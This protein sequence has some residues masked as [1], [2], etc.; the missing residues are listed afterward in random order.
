[1]SI[2]STQH[3]APAPIREN[4]SCVFSSRTVCYTVRPVKYFRRFGWMLCQWAVRS[5]TSVD[6]HHP[7]FTAL[8]Q[9]SAIPLPSYPSLFGHRLVIG[10]RKFGEKWAWPVTDLSWSAESGGFSD[11]CCDSVLERTWLGWGQL[12][13]GTDAAWPPLP[14]STQEPGVG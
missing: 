14:G 3:F 9:N 5:A 7:W 11:S 13:K 1:M 4:N 10:R 12:L 6:G 8:R 2:F